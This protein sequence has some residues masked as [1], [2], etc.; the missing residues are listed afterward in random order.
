M[1]NFALYLTT[2]LHASCLSFSPKSD[3]QYIPKMNPNLIE[4]DGRIGAYKMQAQLGRGHFTVVQSAVFA[5]PLD[6]EPGASSAPTPPD[7]AI[8]PPPT[9]E[10]NAMGRFTSGTTVAIKSIDKVSTQGES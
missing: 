5:E 2:T 10:S 3:F 4:T 1:I 7:S 8:K 6:H 9:S